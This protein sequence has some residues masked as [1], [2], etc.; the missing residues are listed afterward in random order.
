MNLLQNRDSLG[1]P[2]AVDAG[3]Q[4]HEQINCNRCDM[5]LGTV[6]WADQAAL[7]QAGSTGGTIGKT[8][9]SASGGEESKS[10]ATKPH[11]SS[12]CGKVL[13]VWTWSWSGNTRRVVLKPDGTTSNSDGNEGFWTCTSGAVTV[14]WNKGGGPDNLMLSSNGKLLS[15]TGAFGVALTGSRN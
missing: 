11:T 14:T 6:G 4:R 13:G 2:C 10:K 3:G 12:S 15:G 1:Y 9:K 5:R 8:D 7:G